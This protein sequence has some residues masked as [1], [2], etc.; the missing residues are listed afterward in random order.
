[1]DPTNVCEIDFENLKF[2]PFDSNNII[3][4]NM[5]YPD[6]NLFSQNFENL[7]T[8]YFLPEDLTNNFK[9]VKDYYFSILHVNIISIS[10]NFDKLKLFLFHFSFQFK[11]S[12]LTEAWSHDNE[13]IKNSNFQLLDYTVIHQFCNIKKKKKNT[14]VA[15][16][17]LFIIL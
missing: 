3:P 10:K 9:S 2:D 16:V 14:E 7:K 12:C 17:V 8:Q 15:R 13:I 5:S 1:M 6:Y 4:G 11:I